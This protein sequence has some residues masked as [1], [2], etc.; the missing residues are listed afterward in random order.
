MTTVAMTTV[1]TFDHFRSW[2]MTFLVV[3]QILKF[4][5]LKREIHISKP[6]FEIESVNGK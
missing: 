2:Q 6:S 1:D 3:N 5:F 4:L